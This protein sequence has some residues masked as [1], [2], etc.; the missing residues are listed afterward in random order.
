MYLYL[1][2]RILYDSIPVITKYIFTGEKIMPKLTI[3]KSDILDDWYLIERAE[4]DGKTWFEYHEY[5]ASL[6][7]SSRLGNAGIEGNFDE[8]LKIADAIQKRSSV[9]FKRCEI[10]YDNNVFYFASPRNTD[11]DTRVPISISEADELAEQIISTKEK[12]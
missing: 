10:E 8:M 3:T 9:S 7:C 6:M 5:G 2:C 4:H 12:L 1:T 11:Y